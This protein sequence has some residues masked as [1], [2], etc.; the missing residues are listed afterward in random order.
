MESPCRVMDAFRPSRKVSLK[1]GSEVSLLHLPS[2]A[3][4]PALGRR[5][6]GCW[7]TLLSTSEKAEEE[8]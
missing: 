1:G 2:V 3:F 7:G 5:S 8:I 6:S 4:L